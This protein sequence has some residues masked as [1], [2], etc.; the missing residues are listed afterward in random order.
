MVRINN[1]EYAWGDI[2]VTLFGRPVTGITGIEYK[3]KKAKE[4]KFGSGRHAKSIQHGKREIEGTITLMQSE[5]IAL[6]QAAR[7]KGYK[8]ILDV[9]FDILVSYMDGVAITT[10]KIVCVSISELPAGMKEG[11]TQSEHALPFLALDIDY[12]VTATV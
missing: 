9:D 11:D 6:N 12:D 10:D 4:A 8:D 1:K 2:I 3:T 7:Q 5:I